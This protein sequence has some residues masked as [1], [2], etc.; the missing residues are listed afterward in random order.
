FGQFRPHLFGATF[1]P[2][3][4]QIFPGAREAR[5]APTKW[6]QYRS[7][8]ATQRYYLFRPQNIAAPDKTAFDPIHDPSVVFLPLRRLISNYP[9]DCQ[10]DEFLGL[11][12]RHFQAMKYLD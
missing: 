7:S 4:R 8:L 12:L 2:R 10:I 6:T 5:A 3:P 9:V 11:H 1:V